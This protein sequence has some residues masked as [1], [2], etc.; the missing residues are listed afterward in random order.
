M[1]HLAFLTMFSHGPL[2]SAHAVLGIVV[3]LLAVLAFF[4]VWARRAVLYVLAAQIVLGLVTAAMS[5]LMPQAL[6]ALLAVLVGGVYA[7]ANAA[8]RKGRPLAVV[9]GLLGLAFV[10]VAAVYYIGE[11]ALR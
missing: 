3:L 8:E 5:G 4:F 11:H 9:R 1:R 6:H 2:L 10:M 7:A